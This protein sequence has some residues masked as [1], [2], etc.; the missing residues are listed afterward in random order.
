MASAADD[1]WVAPGDRLGQVAEYEAGAGT[2]VR[3]A[4]VVASLVGCKQVVGD[5]KAT[6]KAT[7]VVQSVAHAAA[8][9]PEVGSL[10][11][12]KVTRITKQLA[13]VAIVCVGDVPLQEPFSGIIRKENIR[14][15]EIDKVGVSSALLHS[16]ASHPTPS[17]SKSPTAFV[18]AMLYVPRLSPLVIAVPTTSPLPAWSLVWC[19]PLLRALAHLWCPSAGRKCRT[20]PH[21]RASLEKLPRWRCEREQNSC[22]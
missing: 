21:E 22:Y 5:K 6:T 2:Y 14:E 13:N 15:M 16:S 1:Q 7:L 12:V 17:R 18:L 20:P 11:T 8:T 3:G 4:H 19:M 9:V 10:V